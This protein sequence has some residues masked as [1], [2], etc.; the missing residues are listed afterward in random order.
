MAIAVANA[1]LYE[2]IQMQVETL[3]RL[4][5][6]LALANRHKSEFLATMS[7]EL[8]T[9]L[10]AIIGFSELL[11]DDIVLDPEDRAQCLTD[12]HTSATHLLSLINDVL[13]VAKIESGKMEMHLVPFDV[14]EELAE[15][16]RLMTPLVAAHRQTLT[17]AVA[18]ETP[19]TYADRAR[20]RQVVLNVLSNANK[21]TP[22]GGSITVVCDRV[23]RG[24]AE[25]AEWRNEKTRSASSASP[26][27]PP[28]P[29]VRV[30]VTDTGIGIRP[31]DAAKVF[32]E[33]RQIDGSLSRQ[34]GGTGLGLA[35]SKRLIEMQGGTISFEST[36][37]VG[38]TF[39]VTVP[40]A[41]SWSTG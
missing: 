5:D 17:I 30:R 19:L 2:Q 8:R 39:T 18:P 10:N 36:P 31:E 6:D 13:D 4:N 16:E 26:P 21:F 25:K 14:R 12:I 15:A 35:L 34:Y 22:D 1:R 24:E 23:A 37:G 3:R 38:T 41:R 32:E 9:P 27:S 33:F 28:S 11:A 40:G 29:H 20:F 7:H